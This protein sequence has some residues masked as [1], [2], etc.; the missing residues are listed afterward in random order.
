LKHFF[1]FGGNESIIKSTKSE[2]LK[3]TKR[4]KKWMQQKK[5]RKKQLK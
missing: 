4:K 5:G 2:T 1:V 3:D